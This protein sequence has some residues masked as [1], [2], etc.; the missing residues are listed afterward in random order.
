MTSA[1]AISRA[2]VAVRG[3]ARETTTVSG[4]CGASLTSLESSGQARLESNTTRR[5]WWW[6][7]STRAVSC[8]SSASAVPMP[9]ATA[10]TCERQRWAR[11]RLPSLEI[12]CE[13][14]VRV[15]TLPVERHR[16]LEEH[17]RAPG[18]RVLAEGLVDAAARRRQLAVGRPSTSTPSSRRIPSPRPEAFSVG[19]S[20]ATTTRAIPAATIA[21]VQGGV[22]P[23]WQQG[24]SDTY[25]VAPRRSAPPAAR[26]RLDLG[27]RAA[28]S[29]SW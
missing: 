26:D 17:A 23:W 13:S 14:P 4:T 24:S 1:P 15:A 8:G 9:T 2:S 16:R 25:S 11:R 3:A 22:R 28:V 6:T 21:S 27:V 29:R 5:G 19:S 10:S 12:H 20:E 7:P 18:A